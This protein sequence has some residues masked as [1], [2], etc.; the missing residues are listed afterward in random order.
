MKELLEAFYQVAMQLTQK[1]RRLRIGLQDLEEAQRRNETQSLSDEERDRFEKAVR[2]HTVILQA[3]I[4]ETEDMIDEAK[5]RLWTKS[6]E[7]E[8]RALTPEQYAE[9][10]IGGGEE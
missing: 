10:A 4:S 6:A 9:M 3:M 2:H 1:I 5:H 7:T 8:V